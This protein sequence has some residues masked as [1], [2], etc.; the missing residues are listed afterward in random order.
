MRYLGNHP[1]T[2]GRP[3]AALAARGEE[4]REKGGARRRGATAPE[5]FLLRGRGGLG[6]GRPAMV[7]SRWLVLLSLVRLHPLAVAQT[8]YV[9][10]QDL[11]SEPRPLRLQV[12]TPWRLAAEPARKAPPPVQARGAREATTLPQPPARTGTLASLRQTLARYAAGGR[13]CGSGVGIGRAWHD[14][15][16]ALEGYAVLRNA[17]VSPNVAR[18]WCAG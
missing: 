7:P 3:P 12:L 13:K 5:G 17:L 1:R 18:C 16:A 4:E 9:A 8:R 6:S 15:S 14:R 2:E 10:S 11:E